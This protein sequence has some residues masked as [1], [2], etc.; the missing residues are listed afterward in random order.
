MVACGVSVHVTSKVFS[1]TYM[2]AKAWA[3][4]SCSI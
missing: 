2:T 4:V 1:V 3:K